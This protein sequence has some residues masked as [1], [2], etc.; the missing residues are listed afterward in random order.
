MLDSMF[1]NLVVVTVDEYMNRKMGFVWLGQIRAR[2]YIVAHRLSGSC[3]QILPRPHLE[4]HWITGAAWFDSPAMEKVAMNVP[5]VHFEA[6]LS[7]KSHCH[8][9]EV[10]GTRYQVG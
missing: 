4:S 7:P 9:G 5:G 6:S 1:G 3:A 8:P 2:V 10:H